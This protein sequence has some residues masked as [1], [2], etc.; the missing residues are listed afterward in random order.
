MTS[1]RSYRGVLDQ[2]VV[3]KEIENGKNTQF[4]PAFADIMVQMID[5]NK[6]FRMREL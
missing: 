2:S 6:E 4:D 1:H 5:E 3:R